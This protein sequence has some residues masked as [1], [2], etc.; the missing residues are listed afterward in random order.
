MYSASDSSSH[1]SSDSVNCHNA[2][3][4]EEEKVVVVA[5]APVVTVEEDSNDIDCGNVD[6]FPTVPPAFEEEPKPSST[7][8][9]AL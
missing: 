9:G 4:E 3:E 5:E 6:N 1:E 8:A 7:M 2:S